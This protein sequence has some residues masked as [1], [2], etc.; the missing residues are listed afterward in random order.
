VPDVIVQ[1][2]TAY[3]AIPAGTGPWPGVVV[4]HE[5]FGLNA[6]IRD[7]ADRL[8]AEG[9]LALAPDLYRGK[10]WLR[11]VRGVFREMHAGQGPSFEAIEACRE[12]LAGRGDCTGRTGVIG[13]CMGGGF[14]LLC[15]PRKFSAASVNYGEVPADAVRVL[16]G[17]CPI[18]A[19][20]GA[21]DPMGQAHPRRLEA[22][23]TALDV[24]HDVKVYPDAGH[25]F[26]G[27]RP[28]ALA[29]LAALV[30]L[31]F[32]PEAAEDSWRRI[33][34]FFGEHLGTAA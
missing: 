3:L 1:L 13:F 15:A 22:A 34:A 25:G 18:V 5:A 27:R 16:A 24:P 11:C 30:R 26:M 9:Y 29:P 28:A 19:S 12:W 10:S 8:A 23:L 31:D 4:I 21:K 17:S 20:Y 14:A 32:K 33:L 2:R 6:D 7:Q